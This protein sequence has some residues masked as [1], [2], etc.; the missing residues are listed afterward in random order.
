MNLLASIPSPS[1]GVWQLGPIPIRAYALCIIIGVV[2]AVWLSNR[3]WV[4]RGGAPG[5]M[6]DIAVWAVPFGLVGARLYH[7]I[8]DY[9]LYFGEGRDPLSALYIW[10]GG[11]GVWGAIAFGALGA[12]IA[13]KRRGIP[14]PAIA[15]AAAPGVVIAQAAG[16]F[17]NWFNQELFGKPTTLP[18]GLEIDAAH[19]PSGFETFETFHPTFLY[20]ILWNVGVAALVIWADRRF[21]LGHGRAFALYVMGYTA[22]RAWIEYMRIDEVNHILG[23]R[24]NVWTSVLVFLG[25]VA[26]FVISSRLR[27]GRE[28]PASLNPQPDPDPSD[29]SAEKPENAEDDEPDSKSDSET[30]EKAETPDEPAETAAEEP[31]PERK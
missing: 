17:G 22:G 28:D 5:T 8:T 23:L 7:V 9:Q 30:D 1:Q 15:D 26:Y 21:K 29:E 20:E 13:C 4:A 11:L 10:K 25:G 3:R 16:R 18:W 27:P 2:I 19:R 12:W 24:L 31:T 6:S 14:L